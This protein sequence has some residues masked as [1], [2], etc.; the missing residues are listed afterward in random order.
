MTDYYWHNI[1]GPYTQPWWDYLRNYGVITTGFEGR[2]GDRGEKLLRRY[3]AGDI[4]FAYANRFGVLAAAVIEKPDSY[5]LLKKSDK[6][7][8]H[9]SNHRHRLNVTWICAFEKLG[10]GIQFKDFNKKFDLYF[11]RGTSQEIK[12]RTGAINLLKF[13]KKTSQIPTVMSIPEEVV[14]SG[15]YEEGS[16]TIISVNSYERNG[17]ARKK[18]L[19]CYG[20]SCIACG[21]NF[22]E[23]YGDAGDDFIHVH[24]LKSLSIIRKTYKV[25]PIKD[26][27]PVCPNCH[28]MIH[29]ASEPYSIAK[30]KKMIK[31]NLVS[32]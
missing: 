31:E 8:I 14:N 5:R 17:E 16:T 12:N 13:L 20:Y 27:V 18:C 2:K 1:G 7:M 6:E 19:E 32:K 24:H 30:I 4:I 10:N 22:K 9:N 26:L 29:R 21:F 15:E 25:N 3:K 23:V 28:A 11:P